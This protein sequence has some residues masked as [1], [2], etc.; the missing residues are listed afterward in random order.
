MRHLTIWKFIFKTAFYI[1]IILTLLYIY[2]FM[3]AGG[4]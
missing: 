3:H 2:S 1:M 4:G